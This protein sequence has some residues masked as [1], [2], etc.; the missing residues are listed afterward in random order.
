MRLVSSKIWRAFPELDPYD[1]A[2]CQRYIT[3]ARQVRRSGLHQLAILITLV[4]SLALAITLA[5]PHFYALE[6]IASMLSR[7]GKVD[8]MTDTLLNL[9]VFV[10]FIW[11]PAL[12]ALIVRDR[13]LYA[14]LRQHLGGAI[15]PGCRYSLIGLEI[16]GPSGMPIVKCPECGDEVKLNH[17]SLTEADI[18]P[19]LA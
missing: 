14:C 2:T 13:L 17:H 18:N 5:A 8:A 9:L 3:R 7:H 1:D 19:E 16:Y 12:A 15:C 11:V 6:W 4:V 10:S